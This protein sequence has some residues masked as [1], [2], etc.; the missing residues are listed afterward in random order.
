MWTGGCSSQ[1]FVI[2][3]GGNVD[4]NKRWVSDIRK[5]S[6]KMP[7]KRKSTSLASVPN[8]KDGPRSLRSG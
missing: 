6:P 3:N 1:I 8:M 7:K 4:Y 5:S 2:I